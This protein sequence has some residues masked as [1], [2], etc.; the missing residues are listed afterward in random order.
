VYEG[1][2]ITSQ[3]LSGGV[4][5]IFIKSTYTSSEPDEPWL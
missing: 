3:L 2:P 1:A 5:N 4:I